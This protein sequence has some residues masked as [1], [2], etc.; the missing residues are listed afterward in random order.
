MIGWE[1][2]LR[3]LSETGRGDAP[4]NCRTEEIGRRHRWAISGL[5]SESRCGEMRGRSWK[6]NGPE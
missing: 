2:L 5:S 4:M 6:G 3:D 1:S